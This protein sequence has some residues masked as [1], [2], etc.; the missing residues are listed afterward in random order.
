MLIRHN[1]RDKRYFDLFR[2][3]VVTGESELEFENPDFYDLFTDSDLPLRLAARL[4]A[5]GTAE[6]FERQADGS[7]KPFT[8]IPIGD[9]DSPISST[10]APTARRSI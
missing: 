10:S 3:N 8:E 1:Q 5:D 7:W 6:W 4:N 9:V 2:V